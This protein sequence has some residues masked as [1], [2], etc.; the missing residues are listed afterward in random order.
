[1]RRKMNVKPRILLQTLGKRG[2]IH[3]KKLI[4]ILLFLKKN[5]LNISF[6]FVILNFS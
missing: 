2:A 5:I 3:F 6:N 4:L 1:M